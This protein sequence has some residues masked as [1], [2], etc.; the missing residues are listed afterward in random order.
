MNDRDLEAIDYFRTNDLLEDPYPYYDFLRAQCPVVR[1]PHHGVY[2]VTGYDEIV[3]VEADP[4]GFSS[5]NQA[6][7]P[8]P[9]FPVPLEGD[10]V[11]EIVAQHREG[12]PM[13]RNILTAD[14]PRHT[15][16]RALVARHFTPKRL[17]DTKPFMERV[18]DQLIDEFVDKGQFEL[19]TDFSGPFALLNICELLGVPE[20]D[21]GEFRRELMGPHRDR[22][23]GSTSAPTPAEPFGFAHARFR[24]Y[25][26]ECRARP[27]SD[28]LTSV[29]N[30]PYPDG[31]MPE[32]N[33]VVMLASTLFVAG[34]GTTA[35]MLASAFR[36]LGESP[37]LQERLRDTPEL[38]PN[39]IEETLRFDGPVKGGFRLSIVPKVVGGVAVP[40]GSHV[41]LMF[42]AANHDPSRFECPEEFHTDR[43]NARRHL[44]FGH[45]IHTCAGAPLARAEGRVAVRR[46]LDRLGHIRIAETVH[47]PSGARTYDYMPTYQLRHL[48]H[49]NLEFTPPGHPAAN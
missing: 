37:D 3:A 26:E 28:V 24:T 6:S 22:G 41:M 21:H 27:R 29:S 11:S 49:L 35:A 45:G 23:L 18:A 46:L 12:L 14:P 47:G 25:V 44:S 4:Q 16:L 15:A 34:T 8:F 5:C 38:I 20:S 19:I 48:D 1:E 36:I 2:M 42:A 17:A 30:A 10:D 13:G 31:T 7:G 32:V 40:A 33:D 43:A 9:G 39:F